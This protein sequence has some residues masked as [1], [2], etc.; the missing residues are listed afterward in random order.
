MKNIIYIPTKTSYNLIASQI[1]KLKTKI[2]QFCRTVPM[3]LNLTHKKTQY[4]S[5]SS[6]SRLYYIS[7]LLT[8][9]NVLNESIWPNTPIYDFSKNQINYWNL[10]KQF[11]I[12]EFMCNFI[13]YL[14][15]SK[16]IVCIKI[17]FINKD[18]QIFLKILASRAGCPVT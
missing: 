5:K 13:F 6:S 3:D 15:K 11:F 7:L 14:N 2:Y 9:V 1:K 4:F 18:K 17:Y 8:I 10:T 12:V 16:I